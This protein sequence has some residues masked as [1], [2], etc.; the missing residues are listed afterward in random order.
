MPRR[1]QVLRIGADGHFD[2]APE[3]V[4][5][6]VKALVRAGCCVVTWK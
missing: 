3:H 1:R 2:A 5:E 4:K 6:H